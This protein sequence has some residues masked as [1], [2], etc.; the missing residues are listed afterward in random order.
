MIYEIPEAVKTTLKNNL[1]RLDSISESLKKKRDFCFTGCGTAF[2]TGMLG[3]NILS[4]NDD[5]EIRL[6]CVQALE[7]VGQPRSRNSATIGISHSG[8]TKTTLDALRSSRTHGAFCL[9]VTHF[10]DSP[11]S[12]VADE[13]LVVGNGPDKS[14]CHTKCYVAGATALTQVGLELLERNNLSKSKHLVEIREELPE[15]AEMAR[16]SLNTTDHAMKELAEKHSDKR[17]F[18]FA[19]AGPSYPNALEAALKVMETSYVPAQGFQ[20]EQLLHGPWVS[21]DDE[22][23]VFVMAA[24]GPS[25][26]RSMDLAKAAA[27]L[28]STVIP[29]VQEGDRKMNT[30][31]DDVI[32]C[33][34]VDENLSPFLTIIPLYLFAY[35]MCLER[36]YNPDY[37][38]YLTPRYWNARQAIFPPGT[39]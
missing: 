26:E 17:T 2:F 32:E 27:S 7:L 16:R 12:Q 10:P 4:L 31:S 37:L 9:G 20:T 14:R 38:R 34:S 33:P 6:E 21:L 18:Y 23:L 11:I 30:I 3:A 22:S 35:Y 29:I 1:H 13:T 8:I 15:L 28:G 39:H 25:H 24:D 36:G 5:R 19:G